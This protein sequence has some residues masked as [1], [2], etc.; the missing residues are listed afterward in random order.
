MDCISHGTSAKYKDIIVY[1]YLEI[2]YF[3]D[4]SNRKGLEENDNI[5]IY[6]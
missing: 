3:D 6:N 4:N 2:S 5:T 1:Q